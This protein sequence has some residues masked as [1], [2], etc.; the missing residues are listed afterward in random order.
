MQTTLK[1][2]V[3]RLS[4]S[5]DVFTVRLHVT[6]THNGEGYMHFLPAAM[7]VSRGITIAGKICCGDTFIHTKY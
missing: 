4:F 7:A 6:W 5:W 1:Q 2:E 3:Q